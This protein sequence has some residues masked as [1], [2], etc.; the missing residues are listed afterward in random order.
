M[1]KCLLVVNFVRF[2]GQEILFLLVTFNVRYRYPRVAK[3]SITF[4]LLKISTF[5]SF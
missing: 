4:L 5:S 2:V 3:N 1:L